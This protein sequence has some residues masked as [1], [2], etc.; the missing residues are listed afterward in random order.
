MEGGAIEV[1]NGK[2]VQSFTHEAVE[3]V[4]YS[5]FDYTQS[6]PRCALPQ[7]HVVPLASLSLKMAKSTQMQGKC[8]ATGFLSYFYQAIVASLSTSIQRAPTKTHSPGLPLLSMEARI[9]P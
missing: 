6:G 4:S 5:H 7:S 2:V 9:H 8:G 3:S 1:R